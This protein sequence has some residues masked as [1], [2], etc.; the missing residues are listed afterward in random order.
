MSRSFSLEE[1]W[2]F[3]DWKLVTCPTHQLGS[4][5]P[6]PNSFL[7]LN[8]LW[9]VEARH[10]N[11]S[12][13]L[14]YVMRRR[15]SSVLESISRRKYVHARPKIRCYL[16][17]RLLQSSTA[18]LRCIVLDSDWQSC[19]HVGYYLSF[20]G[21]LRFEVCW[22]WRRKTGWNFRRRCRSQPST[23]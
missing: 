4:V 22:I 19:F 7:Q 3:P 5:S 23:L 10:L 2:H 13:Q 21:N 15:S 18:S 17:K 1:N 16:R 14:T 11:G 9:L 20:H 6:H 12:S 8:T